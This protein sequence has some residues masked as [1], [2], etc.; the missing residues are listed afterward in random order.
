[1]SEHTESLKWTLYI[2]DECGRH[3]HVF[4]ESRPC[5]YGGRHHGKH[6]GPVEVIPAEQ[7]EH[8]EKRA[9]EAHSLLA[10]VLGRF[11]CDDDRDVSIERGMEAALDRLKRILIGEDY[12]ERSIAV[13]EKSDGAFHFTPP[14]PDALPLAAEQESPHGS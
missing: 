14:L 2:C 8:L 12:V 5:D 6:G 13:R 11:R 7:V 3:G 9:D 1:M 10:P 4:Q